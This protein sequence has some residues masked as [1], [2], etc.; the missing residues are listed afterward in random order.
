[1]FRSQFLPH[2]KRRF[3]AAREYLDEVNPSVK[4]MLHSCGSI[5]RFLPDLIEAG[6]DIIDPVQPHA[7]EMDT[8]ELKRDFGDLLT[9]HGGIDIQQILP[10]GTEEEIDAEVIKRISTMGHNGG[11]ILAP[12]HNVQADVP[13]AN[14]VRMCSSARKYGVYPL[15]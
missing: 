13:P 14:I 2:F 10:F 11:Y 4:I 3:R 8:A 9:F 5:R 1:M 6:V 7:A 12:A 15:G